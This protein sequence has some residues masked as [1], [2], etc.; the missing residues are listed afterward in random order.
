MRRAT[1]GTG[2]LR[3]Y[4]DL[5]RR[6]P[7]QAIVLSAVAIGLF[8]LVG[9]FGAAHND[10]SGRRGMDAVAIVLVLLGPLALTVRDRWPLMALAVSLAAAAVYVGRG[11]VYGPIFVSVVVAMIYAIL[12]GRRRETWVLSALGFAGFIVAAAVDPHHHSQS[13]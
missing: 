10:S 5:M 1:D 4:R 9:S 12:A 11:Y 8:Q 6:W 13:L 2:T 7:R 3:A